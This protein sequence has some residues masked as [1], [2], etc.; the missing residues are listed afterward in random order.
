MSTNAQSFFWTN[1]VPD[2]ALLPLTP[3]PN[4]LAE[5]LRSLPGYGAPSDRARDY[6]RDSI[7]L[8]LEHLAGACS[9]W[10][11]GAYLPSEA[12]CRTAFEISVNVRYILQSPEVRASQ[13]QLSSV[14]HERR[15]LRSALQLAEQQGRADLAK[16]VAD[17]LEMLEGQIEVIE[18]LAPKVVDGRIGLD[19]SWPSVRQRLKAL[20][21]DLDY[22]TLYS[23]LC[24][25][26]HGDAEPLVE[27]SLARVVAHGSGRRDELTRALLLHFRET[28]RAFSRMM[29]AQASFRLVTSVGGFADHYGCQ[30]LLE[31]VLASLK[32]IRVLGDEAAAEARVLRES[33]AWKS[34]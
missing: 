17:Q 10:A 31:S 14:L 4:V 16:E 21:E 15:Q 9:A 2:E 18:T 29:V 1:S 7:E 33:D 27:R 5:L 34:G 22:S 19:N 12:S 23:I 20:G 28:T 13:H 30:A 8:G 26:A 24:R 32:A 11:S 3:V 25:S 6:L